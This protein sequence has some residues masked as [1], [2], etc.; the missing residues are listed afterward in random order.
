MNIETLF[1]VLIKPLLQVVGITYYINY[2]RN[3]IN[4]KTEFNILIMG[5]KKLLKSFNKDS[6]WHIQMCQF[7]KKSLR[8]IFATFNCFRFEIKST[9]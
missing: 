1:N 4:K 6:L 3:G 9:L 2:K 7:H 5:I 8:N